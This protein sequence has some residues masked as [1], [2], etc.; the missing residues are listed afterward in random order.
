MDDFSYKEL[1]TK[2]RYFDIVNE[3]AVELLPTSKVEDVLWIIAKTAM[4]NLGFDDCVIYILDT[5]RN[6]L[7][8]RAAHGP[9]NPSKLN[10]FNPIEIEVGRGI[11]GEVALSG[12]AEIVADTRNDKRYIMDDDMRLSEIAV[13]ICYDNH[14]IGVID[15]E[16]PQ[17]NFY[18]QEHLEVI[19]VIALMAAA[20]ISNAIKSE[21][22]EIMTRQLRYEATHD[23]LT[24]LLNR[25]EYERILRDVL[26]RK[27]CRPCRV[28]V[29]CFADVDDFKK[30]NDSF[31]HTA[32]DTYLK[33]IAQNLRQH[34]GEEVA[35]ARIGGDEFSFLFQ[36]IDKEEA[37][38]LCAEFSHS[39]QDVHS[40]RTSDT[41]I[42]LSIGLYA[43]SSDDDNISTVMGCADA[44]SY[45]AKKN[46]STKIC[47][48]DDITDYIA[49]EKAELALLNRLRDAIQRNQFQ[50]VAQEIFP[51][52]ISKKR[53]AFELLL[54]P[55]QN[56]QLP[57]LASKLFK[58]AERHNLLTRINF[59]VVENAFKWL[60]ANQLRIDK[61]VNFIAINLSADSIKNI[62]FQQ[63]L[64]E[65]I[66]NIGV[67]KKRICFEITENIAFHDIPSTADFVRSLRK[68][69]CL[70]A[71]DDFGSGLTS[72][73][74]L[75]Q[76][77]VDILKIDGSFVRKMLQ[78]PREQCIVDSMTY[79]AKKL[80]IVTVAEHVE[81]A[82][83]YEVIKGL[84]IDYVQGFYLDR[85][86]QLQN[87]L[88]Q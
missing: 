51:C 4:A 84:G 65:Q 70:V 79:M 16:H 14:V 42:S 45:A 26:N 29:L 11:V 88:P 35:C 59:W 22:L 15:S 72:F 69:G 18:T 63:F 86:S 56:T 3:L 46:V 19:S 13:P 75:R 48:Y 32:G 64:F 55:G 67:P 40:R 53:R 8:Q 39:M 61:E 81:D 49:Q 28:N 21:K 2:S 60:K 83:T 52:N 43:L 73:D 12:E 27:N 6:V 44:A 54:R 9:K 34:V 5:D 58:A 50:I 24:G 41:P 80:D 25:R 31:G 20:K 17:T 77:P 78:R 33:K 38:R 7:V 57:Q 68:M 87:I 23:A 76:I 10:I 30:V 1:K 71:L 82:E 66:G 36:D 37:K 62:A 85:S 74:H 47:D